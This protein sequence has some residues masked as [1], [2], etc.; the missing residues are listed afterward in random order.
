MLKFVKKKTY[1]KKVVY[2]LALKQ[3][4]EYFVVPVPR[5]FVRIRGVQRRGDCCCEGLIEGVSS[6]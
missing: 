4:S 5:R 6:V 2:G 3:M 1:F